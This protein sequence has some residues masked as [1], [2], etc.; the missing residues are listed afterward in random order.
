MFPD[1][2]IN[3]EYNPRINC[4]KDESNIGGLK[5]TLKNTATQCDYC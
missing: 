5:N 4:F 2:L 1:I 3:Q